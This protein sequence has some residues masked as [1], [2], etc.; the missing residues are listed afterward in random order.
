[1]LSAEFGRERP[2]HCARVKR[3]S[4]ALSCWGLP[5]RQA[6]VSTPNV[7]LDPADPRAGGV[8]THGLLRY[9]VECLEGLL[10][11]CVLLLPVLDPREHLRQ[12]HVVRILVLATMALDLV[13]EYLLALD[14][15]FEGFLACGSGEGLS[16]E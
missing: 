8:V 3:R 1:M 7:I 14:S 5:S 11:I 4:H 2:T 12:I 6:E 9:G 10:S 15:Q 13:K 16:K